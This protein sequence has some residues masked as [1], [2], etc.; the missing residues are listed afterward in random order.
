MAGGAV[1]LDRDGTIIEDLTYLR[2]PEDLRLLPRAAEAIA[3]LNDAEIPVIVV[4]NQ[5]AVARGFV[6]PETLQAIHARLHAEL[7]GGGAH[8]DGIY[9]CPHHPDDGCECRKP[10]PGLLR[11][12]A[13]EHHLELAA[14]YMIGDRAADI[15]AGRA[16]GC[17]TVLVET[18]PDSGERETPGEA[19]DRRA[20]DLYEA[21]EWILT[22]GR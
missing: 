17:T 8:V 6:D 4:T 5:S 21:V 18:G 14:S 16:A 2:R 15:L 9:V 13:A 19:L 7:A 3:R 22:R 12:A 11:Q 20:R 10:R 1:F